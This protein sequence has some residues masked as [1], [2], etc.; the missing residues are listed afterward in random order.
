MNRAEMPALLV[1]HRRPGFYMRVVQ[2]GEVGAGDEIT[3]VAAGPGRV[4]VAEVALALVLLVGAG[5]LVGSFLKLLHVDPGFKPE[6][7]LTMEL[8]LPGAKYPEPEQAVSFFSRL[9]E[10]VGS[11]PGVVAAGA[12]Q[13]I[14]L[15]SGSKTFMLMDSQEQADATREG[16]PYAAYFQV[17]PDYF[18]AMGIPL[19]RGRPFTAQ[20]AAQ[21]PPVAVIS[22][23]A[24]RVYFPG[25]DPVGKNIRLGSPENWGP[26]LNVVGVVP[27]VNFEDLNHPPAMQVY[28]PH[29]QGALGGAPFTSMVLA[30]RTS[31]PDPAALTGQIKEQVRS[32]DKDQPVAKVATLEQ[33]LKD[34]LAQRRLTMILLG[35]FAAMALLL[36]ALGLYGTLSYLVA[37]RRREIGI[38]IA[39]GARRSNVIRLVVGQG[40]A[41]ALAGIA[42]GLL[43]AYASSRLLESLL[44]GLSPNDPATFLATS[45]VVA[46]VALLACYVPARR[47]AGVDPL[48]V[49]RDE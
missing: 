48:I 1:A 14:P 46:L 21:S 45:L 16:N 28:T 35:A 25:G 19:L 9:T 24:A 3:R 10:H 2:E 22:R 27:D 17:T 43:A 23:K 15:G 38:R 37:R 34:S 49:I 39:L 4:T 26:W 36:S 7:V 47:A 11:L 40:M 6:N 18:R 13:Y 44:Y 41:L 30:V 42:V 31:A 8:T 20:D 29:A 5:L 32:L 33:L 12:T